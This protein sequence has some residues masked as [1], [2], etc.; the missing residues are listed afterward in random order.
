MFPVLLFLG[1]VIPIIEL[2]LLYVLSH[3]IGF[4]ETLGI[5][6]I[7]GFLGVILWRWQ[8]LGTLARFRSSI[9]REMSVGDAILD[10]AM[11]FFAGGLLLAPPNPLNLERNGFDGL[12]GLSAVD[13]VEPWDF[14]KVNLEMVTKTRSTFQFWGLHSILFSILGSRSRT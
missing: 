3:Y 7:T 2:V 13:S 4:W 10:G 12:V 5:I 14:Q 6:F 11:I 9:G 1:I 8:G